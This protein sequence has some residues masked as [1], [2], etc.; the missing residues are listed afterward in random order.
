MNK[1]IYKCIE[2]R[3]TYIP[4]IFLAR[5]Q[6]WKTFHQS[7]HYV[8]STVHESQLSLSDYDCPSAVRL[9]LSEFCQILL[10][11]EFLWCQIVT[12]RLLVMSHYFYQSSFLGSPSPSSWCFWLLSFTARTPVGGM[13]LLGGVCGIICNKLTCRSRHNWTYGQNQLPPTNT[14]T[15]SV[16]NWPGS[17][18][19]LGFSIVLKPCASH[20]CANGQP[21]TRRSWP[22]CVQSLL[23][24]QV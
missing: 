10:P 22:P 20:V 17:H 12:V 15:H 11:S 1:Q 19:T 14:H 3:E 5:S 23:V 18:S 7:N 4:S 6:T 2:K 16:R 21:A 24:A 9:W 8:F 13:W